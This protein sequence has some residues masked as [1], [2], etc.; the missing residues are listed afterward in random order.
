MPSSATSV[1]AE[2]GSD[3]RTVTGP[4]CGAAPAAVANLAPNSPKLANWA[5]LRM[6]PNVAASQNAVVP[7]LLMITS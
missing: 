5:R 6:R 1:G 3:L 7:P 4:R 2:P